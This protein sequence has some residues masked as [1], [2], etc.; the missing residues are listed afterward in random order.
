MKKILPFYLLLTTLVSS[1]YSD[2]AV[3]LSGSTLVALNNYKSDLLVGVGAS[4]VFTKWFSLSMSYD[5]SFKHNTN[6]SNNNQPFL[7]VTDSNK[8]VGEY[9]IDNYRESGYCFIFKSY[10][11]FTIGDLFFGIGTGFEFG[12]YESTYNLHL[13]GN[14]LG[15]VL[16]T[17][18]KFVFNDGNFVAFAK[19]GYL[20]Y[21]IY[22]CLEFNYKEGNNY[23]FGL[24]IEFPWFSFN[25]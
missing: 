4:Y 5:Y 21:P 18:N 25:L 23:L 10:P 8:I 11:K 12:K 24:T 3:N 16:P 2:I 14:G 1:S 9:F 20:F 17:E 15:N 22:T 7:F 6:N 19:V 13:V